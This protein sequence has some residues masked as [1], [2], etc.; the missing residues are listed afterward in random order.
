ML[1]LLLMSALSAGPP[2]DEFVT[3]DPFLP[4]GLN[5][6][7]PSPAGTGASKSVELTNRQVVI[8]CTA[9]AVALFIIVAEGV[10]MCWCRRQQRGVVPI[11]LEQVMLPSPGDAYAAEQL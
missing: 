11:E 3:P 8:V 6:P 10:L 4:S 2:G 1:P 5:S 9:L 7:V